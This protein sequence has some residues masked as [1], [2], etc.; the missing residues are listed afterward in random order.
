MHVRPPSRYVIPLLQQSPGQPFRIRHDLLLVIHELRRPRL[1]ERGRDGGDRVV[2]R[3]P[4]QRGEHRLVDL[5]LQVVEDLLALRR[6]RPDAL[7][8]EDDAGAGAAQA[9]V[10]RRA[11]DVA[12]LERAGGDA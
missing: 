11:D 10:R 2:V 3:A 7:A 5:A 6:C 8:E 4:L 9:L 1:E 12:V